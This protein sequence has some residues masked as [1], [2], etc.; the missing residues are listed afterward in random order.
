MTV[1]ATEVLWQHSCHG[2]WQ[3][4]EIFVLLCQCE[5][6]GHSV[7][8]LHGPWHGEGWAPPCDNA[9]D[10]LHED[11]NHISIHN[12]SVVA[13]N[14]DRTFRSGHQDGGEKTGGPNSLRARNDITIGTWNVISL[15]AAGKGDEQT[16]EM[17]SYEWNILGLC[18]VRWKN[19]GETSIP[20]GH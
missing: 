11:D 1:P 12:G 3:S 9:Q 6:E 10:T 17:K 16:L 4:L 2:P 19:F 15:R 8:S 18:E 13:R 14:K 5:R 20:E 7:N